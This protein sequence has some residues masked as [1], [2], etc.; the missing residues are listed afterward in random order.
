MIRY[1]VGDVVRTRKPHPCGGDQWEVMRTGIDFRIKCLT[2][3]R[4]VMIPRPKFEKSVRA[5]VRS[6][7]D[8]NQTDK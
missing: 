6:G 3:G 8:D 4:V 7:R 5:I 1:Q 2:C